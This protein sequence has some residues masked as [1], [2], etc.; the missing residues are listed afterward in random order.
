MSPMRYQM[1]DQLGQ[2]GTGK[3]FAAIDPESGQR[4]AVK[5]IHEELTTDAGAQA[6]FA[7]EARTA[8]GL[9]LPGIVRISEIGTDEEGVF[10]AMEAMPTGSLAD[11]IETVG[12]LSPTQAVPIIMQAGR[13][14]AAAHTAG[15][16]HGNLKPANILLSVRG[17][18]KLTDFGTARLALQDELTR[19]LAGSDFLAPELLGSE[20]LGHLDKRSD[21]YGLAACLYAALTGE[22]PRAGAAWRVPPHLRG[23]LQQALAEEPDDRFQE[24]DSF[25]GALARVAG[26]T[27]SKGKKTALVAASVAGLLVVGGLVA[28][29]NLE[30][31]DVQPARPAGHQQAAD[32]PQP[33]PDTPPKPVVDHPD[34]DQPAAEGEP[35]AELEPLNVVETVTKNGYAL[36]F[37]ENTGPVP[38]EKPRVDLT[39]YDEAGRSLGTAFGYA[40]FDL[41]EP[42]ERTPIKVL[43]KPY[44]HR[45][46]RYDQKLTVRAPY[47]KTKRL[48]KLEV[49]DQSLSKRPYGTSMEALVKVRNAD[50]APVKFIEATVVLYDGQAKPI[51]ISSGYVKPKP[52][53]PGEEGEAKVLLLP[54]GD[55]S[56]LR[57]QVFLD[58]TVYPD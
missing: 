33:R 2:G 44:P 43:L 15:L 57:W 45:W 26:S 56:P 13:A 30:K 18:A 55:A 52:L 54:K 49:V 28:F 58:A 27:G 50:A 19:E 48:A 7:Y 21:V 32:I 42:G 1:G 6:E 9:E 23:V 5:R 12:Q 35:A 40:T 16:R 11:R 29:L 20:P 14:L 51:E 47:V 41:V 24:V 39:F 10:V 31:K 3:V 25:L 34:Q 17:E 38:I 46:V 22:S 53:A 4:L 8:S 36:G 37:L